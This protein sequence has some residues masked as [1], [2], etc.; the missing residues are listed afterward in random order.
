VTDLAPISA[1][2]LLSDLG[3]LAYP[4]LPDRPGPAYLLVA[5]RETATLRHYDP[6][7]VDYYVTEGDRGVRR[8]LTRATAVPIEVD[9][10]WGL[11]RI[12]DRLRVTNE[13]LTFGGRLS[14]ESVEGVLVAVFAS[15]A[16]LLR[17]GGHSQ[18]WDLGADNLGAYFGRLMIPV[19]YAPGFEG[20]AA[21]ADPVALYA[22]FLADAMARYRASSDLRAGQPD[23]WTLLRAEERRVRACHPREWTDGES[24]RL[25]ASA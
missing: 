9:F 6:E 13:Y 15:P 4:D 10:S 1:A 8:T 14:A 19:D 12:E 25:S 23:V 17:R 24:L 2:A 7:A 11:I 16:P 21:R 22:A 18:E 5:L 20:R 3:F